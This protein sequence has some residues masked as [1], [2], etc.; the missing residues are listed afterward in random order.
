ML[1][2]SVGRSTLEDSRNPATTLPMLPTDGSLICGS[3]GVACLVEQ[4][5]ADLG[6]T[7]RVTELR[8][9]NLSDRLA[10][11]VREHTRYDAVLADR[12]AVEH[13]ER[14]TVLVC[15]TDR[16]ISGELSDR[17]E[18]QTG[19]HGIGRTVGSMPE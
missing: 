2:N 10:H 4:V 19:I 13:T 17:A 18:V 5:V 11:A 16:G 15:R 1:A 7:G 14:Q 6:Q 8:E 12:E 3:A 9:G